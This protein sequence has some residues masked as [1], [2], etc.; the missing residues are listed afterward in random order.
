MQSTSEKMS[1]EVALNEVEKWMD[2]RRVR[3]TKRRNQ[4]EAIEVLADAFIDGSLVLDDETGELTFNLAFPVK[5]KEKIV[6]K[7]RVKVTEV[8]RY[9]EQNR[10]ITGQSIV[11]NYL[12]ASTGLMVAEAGDID[13]EDYGI[14]QAIVG[15]YF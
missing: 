13:S 4:S 1:R 10:K 15:F 9:A 8:N 5:S 12:C 11:M 6:F 7:P 14:V 2:I 3:P